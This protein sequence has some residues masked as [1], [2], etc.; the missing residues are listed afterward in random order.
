MPIGPGPIFHIE[1]VAA[2]RRWQTFALRVALLVVL[3]FVLFLVYV[4]TQALVSGRPLSI[5]DYAE[6]GNPFAAVVLTTQLAV[7]MLAAAGATAGAVCVDKSRGN[8]TLMLTTDLRSAE[9]VLEKISARLLPLMVLIT[10]SL[11][12]LAIATMLGG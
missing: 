3:L 9:I 8:L 1:M 10:A 7:I 2:A 4:N 5:N 6:M 11:P 12:L